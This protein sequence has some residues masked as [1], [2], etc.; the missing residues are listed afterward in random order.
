V[1]DDPVGRVGRPAVAALAVIVGLVAVRLLT[2][3]DM[4]GDEALM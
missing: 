2:F 1:T 3:R 4:T